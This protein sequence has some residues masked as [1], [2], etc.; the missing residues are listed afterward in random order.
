MYIFFFNKF[1]PNSNS[2]NIIKKD[3]EN[4]DYK[5]EK[6]KLVHFYIC[7]MKSC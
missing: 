5:I 3:L 4:V 7:S 2:S 1:V 6:S